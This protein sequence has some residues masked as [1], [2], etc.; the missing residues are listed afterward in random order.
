MM[1]ATTFQTAPIKA[2]SAALAFRS[3]RDAALHEH[4]HGGYTGSVAEKTSYVLIG[5]TTT[6]AEANA[7]IDRLFNARDKR[8]DDKY[9]PAGC[10]E[11][12]GTYI[13]F[14]VAAE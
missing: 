1:G 7:E 13:F 12:N 6:K 11:V 5:A 9:G 10:I 8:I 14:G 4:G 2:E 3:A